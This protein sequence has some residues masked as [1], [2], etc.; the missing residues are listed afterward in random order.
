[1]VTRSGFHPWPLLAAAIGAAMAGLV[2]G[3]LALDRASGGA[4]A[5]RVLPAAGGLWLWIA[6]LLAVGLLAGWLLLRWSPLRALG[7]FPHGPAAALLLGAGVAGAV[8]ALAVGVAWAG[9]QLKDPDLLAPITA[10]LGAGVLIGLG[11]VLAAL[12]RPLAALL[13]R[14][15]HPGVVTPAALLAGAGVI[16]AA[17][18]PPFAEVAKDLPLNPAALAVVAALG[19]AIAAV[20]LRA[21]PPRRVWAGVALAVA[22][23][24]VG[25]AAWSGS[26]AARLALRDAN[27]VV[28]L[29]V[30]GVW[31]LTD[32]DGD[33]YSAY[34]AGG[35]CDDADPRINPGAFDL[36]GNGIDE[37]CRDGDREAVA[38]GDRGR[39]RHAA[40]P[41]EL[42]RRW[43][44]LLIT[45]EALRPDHLSLHGYPRDTTPNLKRLAAHGLVFERAYTAANATRFAVPAMMTGRYLADI[46]LQRFHRYVLVGD[47]NDRIFE[48][49]QAAGWYTE[50]HMGRLVHAG[51]WYGL[52]VGFDRYEGH[53]GADLKRLSAPTLV[54]ATLAALDRAGERPWAVWTHLYEPHEPYLAH[55][56]HPFGNAV[57]DRYDS[58]IAAADAAIGRLVEALEA[59][60]LAERTVIVVTSDHGEEFGEHGR[61]YHGKQ[62]F[63]ESIRVPL[64]IH[65]PGTAPRRVE[66]PVSTIDVAPT[67]ANLAGLPPAADYGARS[68][69]GFL[70]GEQD[71]DWSRRI[72]SECVRNNEDPRAR[73]VAMIEWPHKAI[74][75]LGSDRERLYDLARDPDERDNRA[76]PEAPL[77]RALRDE[78]ARQDEA[79]RAR[80]RAHFVAAEAP[81][82]VQ[83]PPRTVAPGLEWLGSRITEGRVASEN[84]FQLRSWFRATGETRPDIVLR[85]EVRDAD[86][87][88]RQRRD[89]RPLVGMYPTHHWQPGEV[90]EDWSLLRLGSTI[91]GRLHAEISALQGGEVIF[92]PVSVGAFDY[93]PRKGAAEGP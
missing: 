86:G 62:L 33:G 75:E 50:A 44:F 9:G 24:A 42:D 13:R 73:S 72:F 40:L 52:E 27:G 65:V 48:R 91:R 39:V 74:I 68:H 53:S 29:L 23:A 12:H 92:G 93:P 77:L 36:P 57:I 81:A 78:V 60:G 79:V 70:T 28:P 14:I 49:L 19:A 71:E 11:V 15:G 47:G 87:R 82:D 69:V 1:M 46:D 6:P 35:D 90:V 22:L 59:R 3:L 21:V 43:N 37:D 18:Q 88:S 10:L 30:A 16:G 66:A 20:P 89:Y 31:R 8:R 4:G 51:M 38:S 58:E 2:E 7:R 54:P 25:P 26:P 56:A 34:L 76:T 83:G 45:V 17:V 41:P 84:V 63:E 32:G 64:L 55:P 5:L 67:L 61:R 85:L 80:L